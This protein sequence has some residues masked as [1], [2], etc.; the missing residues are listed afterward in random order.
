MEDKCTQQKKHQL[1]DIERNIYL[2]MKRSTPPREPATLKRLR[3][4][5]V[6]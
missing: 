5:S 3:S 1:R 2:R 6:V 4:Q